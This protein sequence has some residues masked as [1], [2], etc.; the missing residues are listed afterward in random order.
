MKPLEY[1]IHMFKRYLEGMKYKKKSISFKMFSVKLLID[2]IKEK[3]KSDITDVAQGDIEGFVKEI[4]SVIT[5][6]KKPYSLA[7]IKF[8]TSSLS[9]FFR[10]LFRS[11][12]ILKNPMEDFEFGVKKVE[13]KKDIFNL[14]EINRF[15][16]S[17]DTVDE[18]GIRDRAIFE[19][20]YSSG[21]RRGEVRNL[22]ISDMDFGGRIL[23]VIEGKGGK[24]RYVPFSEV[25]AYFLK[26]YIDGE[27][28]R[29]VKGL[30]NDCR[31][32]LFVTS[33]GRIHPETIKYRFKKILKELEIRNKYL[34]PH[35][36]RHSTATHLLEAGAD[37]R[38]VQELLG[39][40]DIQ[41]TVKYTHLLIDNLKKVYKSYHPRENE[42]YE[43]IDDQYLENLNR[44]KKEIIQ[45][46]E[47]NKKYE[48]T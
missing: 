1:Y 26:R 34:T 16:D 8:F 46:R 24:D 18:K 10:F 38:Y 2:F 13:S 36:I 14:D 35:S 27:R 29:T 4:S 43:E 32:A 33:H 30:G 40:E 12:L 37:V 5:V 15:L 44:L 31:D 11:D 45:R 7:T 39:H 22:N 3:G 23:K 17:I 28:K 48:R 42:F 25:S 47:I 9:Q 20:M 41:T 21:L 6:R 19:L